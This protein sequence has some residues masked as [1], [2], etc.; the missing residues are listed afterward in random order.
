[1]WCSSEKGVEEL[2]VA[3]RCNIAFYIWCSSDKEIVDLVD[4]MCSSKVSVKVF[5]GCSVMATRMGYRVLVCL[6]MGMA[7]LTRWFQKSSRSG[8][9]VC[10]SFWKFFAMRSSSEI[11]EE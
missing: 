1:M 4:A 7:C 9:S 2:G 3:A 6:K 5:R 8:S 10:N 11:G